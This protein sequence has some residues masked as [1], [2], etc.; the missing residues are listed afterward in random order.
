[1]VD[2]VEDRLL[3]RRCESL[4][5]L[6]ARS[7]RGDA[8]LTVEPRCR[9]AW[10]REREKLDQGS[11]AAEAS[12]E[13]ALVS[14][15]RVSVDVCPLRRQND[16]QER[17]PGSLQF[18]FALEVPRDADSQVVVAEVF[19]SSPAAVMP[20]RDPAFDLLERVAAALL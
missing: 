10:S 3:P 2:G 4:F 7:Q 14:A 11:V 12:E 8:E 16:A 18:G 15:K 17:S 6:F 19:E 9:L 20:H 1:M 13:G 5:V